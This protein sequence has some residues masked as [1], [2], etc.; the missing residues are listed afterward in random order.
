MRKDSMKYIRLTLIFWQ[1]IFINVSCFCQHL[2]SISGRVLDKETKQALAY[3]SVGIKGRYVGTVANEH[4]EFDIHIPAEFA[5][6]TLYISIIGYKNFLSKVVQINPG[7]VLDVYLELHP[8]VLEEVVVTHSLSTYDKLRLAFENVSKNYPVQPFAMKGFYREVK[9][10]NGKYVS[11]I[12]AAVDLYD[13]SAYKRP[14]EKVRHRIEEIDEKGVIRQIR[15][16]YNFLTDKLESQIGMHNNLL[17]YLLIQNPVKYPTKMAAGKDLQENI[18]HVNDQIVFEII[19]KQHDGE[20]KYYLN[21]DTYA[22]IEYSENRKGSYFERRINDSISL[23]YND[24]VKTVKFRSINGLLYPE[25]LKLTWNVDT[26]SLIAKK[27]VHNLATSLEFL[28][29]KIE[30]EDLKLPSLKE[31]MEIY[32]LEWQVA[33]YNV[34]FWENYN[35]IKETPLDKKIT[36]DL[37]REVSLEKQF[38]K[39]NK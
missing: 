4:G 19:E 1:L 3:A 17:A 27:A 29:S 7:K 2:I 33:K 23:K 13:K 18:V 16:S 11:L 5:E 32:S 21:S 35:M 25:L 24:L 14:K 37:E 30:T 12:E 26:Y 8:T 36:A 28:I 34:E 15:K 22:L 39:S 38:R 20:I 31:S 6:D 9:M 10:F